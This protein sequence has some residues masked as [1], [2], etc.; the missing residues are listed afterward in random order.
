MRPQNKHEFYL[1]R[2]IRE[3]YSGSPLILVEMGAHPD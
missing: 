2:P 1:D 3:S